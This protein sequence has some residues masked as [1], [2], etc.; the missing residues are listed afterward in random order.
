MKDG[1]GGAL[2]LPARREPVNTQSRA[3]VVCVVVSVR[4]NA[5]VGTKCRE[6][7]LGYVGYAA[8]PTT[9]RG[10]NGDG[11]NLAPRSLR[12]FVAW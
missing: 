9:M 1:S 4:Q 8:L 11:R 5:V 2:G 3:S 7:K 6:R 12:H 10:G